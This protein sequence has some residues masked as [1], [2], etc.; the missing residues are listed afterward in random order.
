VSSKKGVYPPVA[1]RTEDGSL[2]VTFGR[3]TLTL[4]PEAAAAAYEFMKT[5]QEAS[6]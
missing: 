5:E 3:W 1:E 4:P 6:E 2:A